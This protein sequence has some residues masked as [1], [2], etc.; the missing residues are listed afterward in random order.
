MSKVLE[1]MAHDVAS[2]VL[3]HID[4]MY[5]DM[6]RHAPQSART[7]VRNTII[8]AVL[9]RIFATGEEQTLS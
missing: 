7:S 6:W 3:H 9:K 4:T 5:P 1:D 8:Q 2:E